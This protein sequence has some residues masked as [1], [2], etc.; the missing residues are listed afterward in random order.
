MVRNYLALLLGILILVIPLYMKVFMKI[1]LFS[2]P[3]YKNTPEEE[4]G[5][6]QT[7]T[8]ETSTESGTVPETEEVTESTGI[9]Y[10][11][12]SFVVNI[13]HTEAQRFLKVVIVLELDEKKTSRELSRK[14]SLLRDL[15][16]TIISSKDFRDIEDVRG[17]NNLRKEIIEAINSKL[18]TGKIINVYFE[19]FVAQ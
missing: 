7:E 3:A 17:K 13:A 1:S 5:E 18:E 16:I 2:F 8:F 15:V 14:T 10:Q 6:F 4:T 12:G 19:E 9:Y 11:M